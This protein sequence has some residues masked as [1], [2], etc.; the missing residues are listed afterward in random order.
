[1]ECIDGSQSMDNDLTLKVLS[2]S[3]GR[4]RLLIPKLGLPSYL[5]LFGYRSCPYGVSQLVFRGSAP[6]QVLVQSVLLSQVRSPW[7]R[8]SQLVFRG[9]GPYLGT[10]RSR[11]PKL[12]LQYYHVRDIYVELKNL[13]LTI[14]YKKLFKFFKVV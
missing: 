14:L 8:S 10:D 2:L 5:L 4:R 1:M 3:V 11:D 12:V 9:F 6:T 7:R 13:V